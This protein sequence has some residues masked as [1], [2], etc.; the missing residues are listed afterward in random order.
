M[1][2]Q[3]NLAGIDVGTSKVCSIIANV[4]DQRALRILGVGIV[5]TRGMNKGMI[6]NLEETKLC[7]KE[8][9]RKAERSCGLRIDSAYVG[10]TGR[11]INAMNN[12]GMVAITRG[13]RKVANDDLKRVLDSAKSITV[14]SDRRVLHT[15]TR[16]YT[17][18]G[19]QGVKS[20]VGMH[21]LRLDAETHIV[22]AASASVQNLIKCVRGAGVEVE[23]LV[24]EALASAESVLTHDEMETGVLLLDIGAGTTDIAIFKDGSIWHSVVLPVGGNQ[25]TRDI[26]IGLGIPYDMA[27]E[28]KKKYGNLLVSSVNQKAQIK[29]ACI[30]GDGQTI[31][32]Q[33]LCEIIRARMEEMLRMALL[34]LP[35]SEYINLLPAG[36]VLTGG[37]S[38]LA[39][40]DIMAQEIFRLPCRVGQPGDIFGLAEILYDPSFA[41]SVGLVWWGA[42]HSNE[43]YPT[44]RSLSSR[45][46]SSLDHSLFQFKKA[47]FH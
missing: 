47:L 10:I 15:I 19:Q 28:I 42:R 23:D 36:V 6:V 21:G 17:L 25:I 35:R 8:S 7:I 43:S 13:D 22:T 31:M 24:L 37:V 45:V 16:T 5:P 46:G 34:E 20:P 1:S 39:G 4:S 29:D 11:H 33:D 9:V 27:E 40:I 26:S 18:D 14:P 2:R 38:N 12:K 3:P 44:G 41:T 32:Q 30:G